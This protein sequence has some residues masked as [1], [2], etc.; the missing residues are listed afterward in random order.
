LELLGEQTEFYL[1]GLGPLAG[2]A[3]GWSYYLGDVTRT[4]RQ[5]AD[6]Q[7]EIMLSRRMTP[8]G[9]TLA[10]NGEGNVAWGYFGGLADAAS[11]LI[12]MGNGQYYDPATGRFLTR[13][14]GRL[15]P[16][17]P[18]G[19]DPAGALL[20]PLG[21][22]V[23]LRWRR[24]RKG[25]KM[26]LLLLLLVVGLAFG[27][28]LA[29]CNGGTEPP[30]T[31]TPIPIPPSSTPTPPTPTPQPTNPPTGTPRPPTQTPTT[32]LTCP[33]PT[34]TPI[35]SPTGRLIGLFNM[36][37]YYVPTEDEPRFTSSTVPI[38][39]SYT[40]WSLGR[41][42]SSIG[43]NFFWNDPAGAERANEKFLY[44]SDSVCMQG[45]GK[46]SN[47]RYI[48]C[49]VFVDWNG[50]ASESRRNQENP[51][52]SFI[53]FEWAIDRELTPF[54]TV[55][56]CASGVLSYGNELIIP[57]LQSYLIQHGGDGVLKVADTGGALCTTP[58]ETL[59]LFVG[60]GQ[61]GLDAYI[62]LMSRTDRGEIPEFVTVFKR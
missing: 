10:Q 43:P 62:D 40:K 34:N 13:Q 52:E 1:H 60:E 61:G 35:P 17:V 16:Y 56:R 3:N 57:E 42:L 2:Y 39:S 5:V 33:T 32:P 55:A 44:F 41:Y 30:D 58:Y 4:V 19:G 18:W 11:G 29:A 28:S 53:G 9:K 36:S 22:L 14:P 54:R 12:Y 20:G 26:D 46:L 8:W 38:P 6:A 45:T 37:A 31:G 50:I 59:D 49:S 48:G 7:A 47:G 24:R 21:L 27:L 23:M 15:N 25:G 51:P